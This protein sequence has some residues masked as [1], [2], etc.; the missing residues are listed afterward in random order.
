MKKSLVYTYGAPTLERRFTLEALDTG[1]LHLRAQEAKDGSLQPMTAESLALF[2]ELA[3]I[4]LRKQVELRM[5]G[6]T[7]LGRGDYQYLYALWREFGTEE[8]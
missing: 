4:P 1:E 2:P 3:T 7:T 8:V 6:C 5:L